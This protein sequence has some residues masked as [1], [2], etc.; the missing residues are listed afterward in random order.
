MWGWGTPKNSSIK[1]VE[2]IS[3]WPPNAPRGGGTSRIK[4]T[5]SQNKGQVWLKNQCFHAPLKLSDKDRGAGEIQPHGHSLPN[6][7]S[8]D[9]RYTGQWASVKRKDANLRGVHICKK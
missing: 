7:E 4:P 1:R 2:Q 5:S 9:S 3:H 6:T 8:E